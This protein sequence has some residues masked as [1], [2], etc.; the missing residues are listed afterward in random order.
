MIKEPRRIDLS[1]CAELVLFPDGEVDIYIAEIGKGIS[2]S[3]QEM[4]HLVAEWLSWT[5]NGAR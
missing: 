4:A 2:L 5:E 1:A 3:C